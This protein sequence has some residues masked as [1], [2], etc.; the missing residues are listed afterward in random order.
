MGSVHL[1]TDPVEQTVALSIQHGGTP[2]CP[3]IAP[4]ILLN[5]AHL[6]VYLRC[7]ALV[8]DRLLMPEPMRR[9][10]RVTLAAWL[11]RDLA[12]VVRTD[13]MK[14]S[15]LCRFLKT[16][17]GDHAVMSACLFHTRKDTAGYLACDFELVFAGQSFAR[18]FRRV[19]VE[20]GVAWVSLEDT[21]LLSSVIA[22]SWARRI[23]KWAATGFDPASSS[24]DRVQ[25]RERAHSLLGVIGTGSPLVDPLAT[26]SSVA[27][28]VELKRVFANAIRDAN[29]TRR[30]DKLASRGA[31]TLSGNAT[32]VLSVDPRRFPP[33]VRGAIERV[34]SGSMHLRLATRFFVVSY[35]KSQFG[36]NLAALHLWLLEWRRVAI[37]TTY[38][39]YAITAEKRQWS[40]EVFNILRRPGRSLVHRCAVVAK[41]VY[42]EA[43]D[44][45][46]LCPFAQLNMPPRGGPPAIPR[47]VVMSYLPAASKR[48]R[49][50]SE[51]QDAAAWEGATVKIM[52]RTLERGV[53]PRAPNVTPAT[54]ACAALCGMCQTNS[55]PITQP[56]IK[57]GMRTPCDWLSMF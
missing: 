47:G 41:L 19:F 12:A 42:S 23:N 43:G 36:S 48:D 31:Q 17:F 32:D 40:T 28:K 45:G 13:D 52:S 55:R 37:E 11:C 51:L 14:H 18:R 50:G 6:H 53:D 57:A 21:D 16:A 5:T 3:P 34:A 27:F 30:K 15:S 2:G 1:A 38:A 54:S 56:L 7:M 49:D 29:M 10:C 4:E 25:A 9:Q 35:L 26:E 20:H 8:F 33:C 24:C 22:A 44:T 39:P 46:S